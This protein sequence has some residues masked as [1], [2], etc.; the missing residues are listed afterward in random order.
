MLDELLKN[1]PR[2]N[3]SP[4]EIW[5]NIQMGYDLSDVTKHKVPGKFP[6]LMET[7]LTYQNKMNE[8]KINQNNF[9]YGDLYG[10]HR[11]SK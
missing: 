1:Q 5:Q 9:N 11:I 2:C 4:N 6:P 10:N 3:K 7:V 8:V